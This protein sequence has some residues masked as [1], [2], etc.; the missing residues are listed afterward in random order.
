[1]LLNEI[2]GTAAVKYTPKFAYVGNPAG[3]ISAYTINATDGALTAGASAA[4]GGSVQLVG[5]G[6]G[7]FFSV[8]GQRN[9]LHATLCPDFLQVIQDTECTLDSDLDFACSCSE[10]IGS[11]SVCFL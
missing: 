1:M 7:A 6:L 9:H 11:P 4:I 10:R 3:A 8:A 2:K 5:H